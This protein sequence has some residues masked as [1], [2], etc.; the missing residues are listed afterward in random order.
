MFDSIPQSNEKQ[1]NVNNYASADKSREPLKQNQ[2][3]LMAQHIM[4]T[5]QLQYKMTKDVSF[6]RQTPEQAN[7]LSQSSQQ[8]SISK[9]V[10]FSED[11]SY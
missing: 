3:S 5:K 6:R 8:R 1:E 2:E 11:S 10:S 9:K 4:K 7:D